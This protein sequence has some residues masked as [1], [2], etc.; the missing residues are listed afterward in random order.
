M[1]STF[2]NPKPRLIWPRMLTSWPLSLVGSR[3]F[4]RVVC[5]F[6]VGFDTCCVLSC[7]GRHMVCVSSLMF[8]RNVI[9]A[10]CS[11]CLQLPN[12]RRTQCCGNGKCIDTVRNI[13]EQTKNTTRNCFYL[14][15]CLGL[16]KA[17]H[18]NDEHK[19]VHAKIQH[20][21]TT[22]EYTFCCHHMSRTTERMLH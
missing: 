13:Q 22:R 14:C 2:R 4:A 19:H 7:S 11:S 8:G 12:K 9:L 15:T 20:G 5:D 21:S 3:C 17:G 1:N 6:G 10:F 16:C 18:K